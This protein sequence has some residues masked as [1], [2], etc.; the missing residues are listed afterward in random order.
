MAL[1]DGS[2]QDIATRL[3]DDDLVSISLVNEAADLIQRFGLALEKIEQF[4]HSDGHGRGFTCANIAKEALDFKDKQH[5]E[6]E[7]H[8]LYAV[9]CAFGSD[10]EFDLEDVF[11]TTFQTNDEH[12]AIRLAS[13]ICGE[14]APRS[15]VIINREGEIY[16]LD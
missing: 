14:Q 12:E 3:R 13:C 7:R 16:Y 11:F 10:G 2:W 15:V 4:G 9:P 8:A 6:T 1:Y 5:M